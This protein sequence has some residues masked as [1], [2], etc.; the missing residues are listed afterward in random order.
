MNFGRVTV[1]AET[2]LEDETASIMKRWGADAVRNS[3][4]TKLSAGIKELDA[5]IYSTLCL[6]RAD[7]DYAYAHK[8]FVHHRVLMSR[9]KVT[10]TTGDLTIRL[11]DGFFKRQFEVDFEDDPKAWWEVINR[12]TGTAVPSEKWTMDSS[13]GTVT[14]E[15]PSPGHSYTVNFFVRQIWEPTSMYNHLT[16]N[17]TCR[18]SMGIDPRYPEAGAHLLQWLEKWLSD[19]PDTD[20]VRLTSLFYHFTVTGGENGDPCHTD[21]YGYHDAVSPYALNLFEKEYG[22]RPK[23]EDFIDGGSYSGI[24]CMP[25]RS[26]YDWMEFVQRFVR[27]YARQINDMIHA[28]GKTAMLFFGDHWIGSEPYIPGFNEM[29]FDAIVGSVACGEE[30]RRI[31]DIPGD[32]TKEIRL[33]PYLF[34]DAFDG[35]NDTALNAQNVW[36]HAR[37]ALLRNPSIDRIGY[38]GYLSLAVHDEPFISTVETICNEFREIVTTVGDTRPHTVLRVGILNTWGKSRSWMTGS[39]WYEKFNGKGLPEALAGMPMAVDF[40]NFDDI[41]NGALNSIDVLINEGKAGTTWSGGSNWAD[42]EVQQKI[43]TWV[44]CGGGILGIGEP[45]AHEN[46]GQVFQLATLFGVDKENGQTL[47]TTPANNLSVDNPFF[48]EMRVEAVESHVFPNSENV[49]VL[50]EHNGHVLFSTNKF[51]KGRAVYL[52]RFNYGP[53]QVHSLHRVLL[54]LAG[55]EADYKKHYSDNPNVETAFFDNNTEGFA[56]N[57]TPQPQNASVYDQTGMEYKIT[58]EPFEL[59]KIN[60]TTAE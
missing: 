36:V 14:I 13:A 6:I 27:E 30:L 18:E 57:N 42:T 47:N 35:K 43:K 32:I 21:W 22:Y 56:V 31:A 60:R 58:L 4:G 48:V 37:R 59:K 52:A 40:I 55:K 39:R 50:A 16:N 29:N 8:Q 33:H 5:T 49:N 9:P 15:T 46:S 26:T 51:G 1:P 54:W 10:D 41:K 44:N 20:V 28:A 24:Q 34:P 17:W 3:D 12:T 23:L 2:G 38:G 53:D 19:N 11:L 45:S 25:T 7:Q